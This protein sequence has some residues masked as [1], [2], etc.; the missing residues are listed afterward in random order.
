MHIAES[1]NLPEGRVRMHRVATTGLASITQIGNVGAVNIIYDR[2]LKCFVMA[3]A[4]LPPGWRPVTPYRP[5]KV[6][7]EW[8]AVVGR[9][10]TQGSLE[11]KIGGMYIEY[12]NV[13]D[14]DDVVSAPSFGRDSGDGVEYYNALSGSTNRD[15]LRVPLIAATMGTSD[16]A[17]FPKGNVPTFFAQTSG[18]SGV[19]GRPFSDVNNS[20]VFGGA[21]VATIDEDDHTQDLV[22]S[23]FYLPTG[24]QQVKLATSQIGLE[25][26]LKLK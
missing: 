6:M 14:P 26:E 25:W 9:L 24:E 11:Y 20:K 16:S 8:G 2:E 23:R 21:L 19:H 13:T 10:L 12:E 7:Y 15:Y 4:R 17:K 1:P 18:V 3:P 5:N 22:L